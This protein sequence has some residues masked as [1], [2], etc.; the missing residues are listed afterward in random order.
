M[1]VN[2]LHI[3]LLLSLII[4][5]CSKSRTDWYPYYESQHKTPY[6]TKVFM[7][8]LENLFP[9]VYQKSIKEKTEKFLEDNYLGPGTFFYI[10]PVFFPDKESYQQIVK[11][12]ERPNDIF[13]STSSS[14]SA[15][16]KQFGI[17][18]KSND[19]DT[20]NLRIKNLDIEDQKFSIANRIPKHTSY[21]D[22]IPEFST[23]LGTVEI[24][25]IEKPNYI[26]VFNYKN[27]SAFYFHA[28]PSL[29]SNYH[30]LR[31][32]DGKYA[33]NCMSHLRYTDYIFWD[34]YSTRRRYMTQASDG[35]SNSMLRY[36]HSSKALSYG[37]YTLMTLI[38]LFFAVNYKRVMR[39]S[40]IRRPVKNNSLDYIKVIAALFE[41]ESNKIR[42]AQ[43]RTNYILDR[44]K[45]KYYLDSSDVND[46]FLEALA[47][48]S[49]VPSKKLA[50]FVYQLRKTRENETMDS[51]EF[52]F[53]NKVV[54]EA[55]TLIKLNQ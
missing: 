26:L 50:S 20:F 42:A 36:I 11:Y 47:A 25:S 10:N 27:K 32:D 38:F 1:K 43:Y 6:G 22:S 44:I 45:D 40:P 13:I 17:K 4:T 21:F 33:L 35:S 39:P 30:M 54:E 23:V 51:E 18:I 48:K 19:E 37:L 15:A 28:Q 55:V 46:E 52:L 29:F 3:I 53:F 14:R 49:E 12:A 2:Y 7:E 5:S 34:G 41:G 31:D 8:Q 9:S 16:Y 24:D